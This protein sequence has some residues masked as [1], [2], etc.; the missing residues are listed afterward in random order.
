MTEILVKTGQD[1]LQFDGFKRGDVIVVRE[2]GHEWGGKECPPDFVVLKLPITVGEARKYLEPM[3]ENLLVGASPIKRVAMRR[4]SVDLDAP[5]V[6]H[7]A[8]LTRAQI[9]AHIKLK[10]R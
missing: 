3:E 4:H 1:S 7:N 2:S 6:A 9:L 10:G 5:G 8:T